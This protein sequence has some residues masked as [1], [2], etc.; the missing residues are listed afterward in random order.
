M[1]TT[2]G[3][4][5]EDELISLQTLSFPACELKCCPIKKEYVLKELLSID[6]SKAVE[7]DGIHPRFLKLAAAYIAEP[8]THYL[9]QFYKHVLFQKIL[10]R[11]E[12][13]QYTRE[14]HLMLIVLDPSLC[15]LPCP[16]Y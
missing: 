2:S 11:H 15:Y 16:K 9:M 1:Q 5:S 7:V 10:R 3:N 14:D 13:L 6:R 8:L 4:T 12:L